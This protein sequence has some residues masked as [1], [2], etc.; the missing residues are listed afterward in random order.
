MKKLVILLILALSSFSYSQEEIRK[1][2]LKF[3]KHQDFY[4]FVF[5]FD[6]PETAKSINVNMTSDGLIKI[7]FPEIFKFE[8]E[9]KIL[10]EED[11][12]RGIKINI[13][14][15]SFI[16]KSSQIKEIKVSRYENPSRLVID[17]FF[18]EV[19]KEEKS[20]K[21]FAILIDPGHGGKDEGLQFKENNEKETTLSLAKDIASKLIRKNIKAYLTRAIDDDLSIENRI[22]IENKLKPNLTIS[23]HLSNKDQFT[24]Y[25]SNF[26]NNIKKEDSSKIFLSED[27]LVKLFLKKIKENFS[28]PIYSEKIPI[29][30][31][32]NSISPS[33]MIELPKRIIISDQKYKEKIADLII[34]V[35]EEYSKR[36]GEKYKE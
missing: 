27:N 18:G 24:I 19:S 15:K 31:L 1:V 5:I 29:T 35:V 20:L 28:E 36:Q 14:E 13:K 22:Q 2:Y 3:G 21:N 17:A 9:G 16:I 11:S 6:S 30:F 7:F 34:Q 10:S 12:I 25:T 33:V 32:K 8:F 4:R 23:I 26:K